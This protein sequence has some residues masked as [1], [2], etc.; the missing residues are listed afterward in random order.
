MPEPSN[1]SRRA[2]LANGLA[3]AA[4]SA[5]PRSVRAQARVAPYY[6]PPANPQA[7]APARGLAAINAVLSGVGVY[8]GNEWFNWDERA[9]RFAMAQV[10]AWG[11]GF[12]APKVGG[13]GRTYYRD[14]AHLRQWVED[15]AAIGLGFA[16]FI[17]TIPENTVADAKI[18]AQ[19]GRVVG[20]AN[21]DMEDEWGAREKGAVQGY[22][23]AQMAEF[24]RVYRDEAGQAPVIVNGY[25]DPITRFG[26][27]AD[28][29]PN[30]EMMLWADAYSPQWYIGVY[31]RYK[32][33]GLG[34]AGVQAALDWGRDE[35]RQ[36]LGG[37][38]LIPS[39]ST[40]SSY[41]PDGLLSVPDTRLLANEMRTLNAPVF[42]WEYGQMTSAHA[43]ALL[44]PPR[45]EN[46]RIERLRPT[47]FELSWDTSV[48]ARSI[49]ALNG[50]KAATGSAL[51]LTHTEGTGGLAAGST[52]LVHV[53]AS[54][55]G[56]EASPV[57]LTV[58]TAPATPGV[59]VA[60][61]SAAR[62]AGSHVVVSLTLAN[63]GERAAQQVKLSS[64][65]VQ[66]GTLIS[67]T[68]LPLELSDLGEAD[69]ASRTANRGELSVVVDKIAAETKT[70]TLKLA[71]SSSLGA[72][73][74][75]LPVELPAST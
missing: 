49:F 18:A 43:Q 15:A 31:G 39:I 14:D 24:G 1:L 3:V 67:P 45:V 62:A 28:G 55:A 11:F 25:G 22:K 54:S 16:P 70:L 20:L 73:S 8:V 56:G 65:S 23:G 53:A 9:R 52:T 75:A 60:S 21:V 40:G 37:F 72:W 58:A 51:E 61:A 19:I 27:G 47:S 64:L 32:K 17:Y 46:V 66:G 44:G 34:A 38:P 7:V 36:V 4:A 12:I 10:R 13:Y 29:F 59:Y 68:A 26:R 50:A 48:P 6:T 42:V 30:E 57:L 63:T 5:L 71:G 41:W 33:A 74:A 69:W 35:C 2:L